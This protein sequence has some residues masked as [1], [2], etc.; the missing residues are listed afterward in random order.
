MKENIEKQNSAQKLKMMN[1]KSRQVMV[2]LVKNLSPFFKL[3]AKW[4]YMQPYIDEN[5][6]IATQILQML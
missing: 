6:L 5:N 1:K 2:N 3:F 4:K